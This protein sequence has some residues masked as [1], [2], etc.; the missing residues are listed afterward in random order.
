[1]DLELPHS[2]DP[3]FTLSAVT[4]D[5][6]LCS[7]SLLLSFLSLPLPPLTQLTLLQPYEA[8]ISL[9][10]VFSRLSAA[11]RLPELSPVSILLRMAGAGG[12]AVPLLAATANA[13]VPYDAP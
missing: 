2:D 8:W 5:V 4:N 9:H 12:P 6:T 10:S 1:M 7:P 13:F 3:D 11:S